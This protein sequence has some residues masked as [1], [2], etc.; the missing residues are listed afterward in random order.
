MFIQKRLLSHLDS[1]MGVLDGYTMKHNIH[2]S[3][4]Q[5]FCTR[6]TDNNIGADGATALVEGLK[7]LKK[8]EKLDLRS[9]FWMVVS[10]LR[11][12]YHYVV[13]TVIA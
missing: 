3:I 1:G 11:L 2:L 7:E 12:N 6:A 8:L 9:E 10:S 4:T 13:S 5:L